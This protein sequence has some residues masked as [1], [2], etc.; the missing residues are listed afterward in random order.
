MKDCAQNIAHC[1]NPKEGENVYI[2]GNACFQ[3]IME[4]VALELLR[5]KALPFISSLSDE[6]YTNIFTDESILPETLE[7]VPRHM[8]EMTKS[9]DTRITFPYYM[10]PLVKL[11]SSKDISAALIK[12]HSTLNACVNGTHPPAKKLL[13]VGWP[14]AEAARYYNIDPREFERL[15]TQGISVSSTKLSMITVLLMQ[16][17]FSA[18]IIHVSDDFGTD[19]WVNVQ[20]RPCGRDHGLISDENIKAGD[21]GSNLP[22]GEIGWAPQE[23]KG[24]GILFCPISTNIMSRKIIKN[25]S[26][27]FK[28]GKFLINKITADTDVQD[29][30]N[31]FKIHMERDKTDIS[32]K[33]NR[34][35][36]IAELGIG[37]NPKIKET[38]GY[39]V[40]DEKS[41]GS[42]H[43]AAGSN[44][45][46]GGTSRSSLHWDFVTAPHANIE[47]EYID[48][49]KKLVMENGKWITHY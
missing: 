24:E 33:K 17:F 16:K 13:Y 34:T 15:V 21:M 30:I 20:N 4:E 48:G 37:C 5:K 31:T 46:F 43:L 49:N 22:A 18:K 47:V 14:T 32:I 38:I 8:L 12:S 40:S 7:M 3:D 1:V 45:Q 25:L 36:N 27:P 10:D 11:R 2:R 29:I 44:V 9:I 19:F 6:Y 42:V 28:D 23:I 26:L 35:L 39:I 41:S